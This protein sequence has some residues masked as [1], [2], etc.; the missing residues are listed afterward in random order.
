[1]K[2]FFKYGEEVEGY[3]VRVVNEREARAGA[4]LLFAFGLLSLTNSVMLH[5]VMFT[6]YFITF[7]T[8]DFLIRVINPSYSPSLLLGRFFVRNQIP[9]YVGAAQKRFAWLIGLVLAL[10]MFYLLVINFAPNPIKIL[11]CIICLVLLLSESAFSIC[12]GCMIYNFINK[13]KSKNCPGGAC[14]I[15]RKDKIQ[16]FNLA[17]KI[18]VIF[19]TLLITYGLY[20]YMT[21]VENK[22]FLMKK[23]TLMMMSEVELKALKEKQMQEEFDKNDF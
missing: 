6:K 21:K 20:A 10:P 18:I 12:F 11:I 4:G 19:F 14:E 15:R 22:T 13:E 8:F 16:T 7:F 17:Q 9:E 23:V 3:D 2:E 5:N 1:M